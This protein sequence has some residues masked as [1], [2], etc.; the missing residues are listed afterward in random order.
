MFV[1]EEERKNLKKNIVENKSFAVE[2]K[3][4]DLSLT[5]F[6]FGCCHPM[7]STSMFQKSNIHQ[8]H[9]Q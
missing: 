8:M 6:P 4:S 3:M 7:C 2:L 5:L 1:T 9:T